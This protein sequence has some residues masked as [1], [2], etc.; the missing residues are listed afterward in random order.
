MR[1]QHD[2]SEST[3]DSIVMELELVAGPDFVQPAH[4]QGAHRF[5]LPVNITPVNDAPVLSIPAGKTLRLAQVG[6]TSLKELEMRW[7]SLS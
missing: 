6:H 3:R 1:Y 2:G 5:A 7:G 4:L